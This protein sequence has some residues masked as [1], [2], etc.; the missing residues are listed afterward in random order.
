VWHRHSSARLNIFACRFEIT[1]PVSAAVRAKAQARLQQWEQEQQAIHGTHVKAELGRLELQDADLVNDTWWVS[2]VCSAFV[3]SEAILPW[4]CQGG[5][6]PQSQVP[7]A[8]AGDPPDKT[9]QQAGRHLPTCHVW[10]APV[11]LHEGNSHSFRA[12]LLAGPTSLTS[13]WTSS[14]SSSVRTIQY[15]SALWGLTAQSRRQ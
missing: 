13:P 7:P 4:C 1:A 11:R 9:L 3:K 8:A 5:A 12:Q 14:S 6:G 10:S 2:W 15:V